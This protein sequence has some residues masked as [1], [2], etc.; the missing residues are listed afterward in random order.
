MKHKIKII[1]IFWVLLVIAALATSCGS[2]N[3][4]RTSYGCG[5]TKVQRHLRHSQYRFQHAAAQYI[6][7]H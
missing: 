4:S 7:D 1:A 6:K 2:T 3:Y 5:E